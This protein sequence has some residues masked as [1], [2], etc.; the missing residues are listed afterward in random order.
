MRGKRF[1]LRSSIRMASGRPRAYLLHLK[2]KY[3]GLG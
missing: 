1:G 2:Q 3:F